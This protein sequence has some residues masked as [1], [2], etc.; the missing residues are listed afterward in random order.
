MSEYDLEM[1]SLSKEEAT[2]SQILEICEKYG[3]CVIDS[4]LDGDMLESVRLD[5]YRLYDDVHYDGV[6]L[7]RNL[8]YHKALNID[9]EELDKSEFPA[10]TDL[11]STSLFEGVTR[12]YFSEDDVQYPANLWAAKSLGT[13]DSPSGEPSDGTPFAYHFD[14]LNKF[15]FFFYL[16]DVGLDD[17]PTHFV[18]EYHKQYKEHR[19][20]WL[21]QNGDRSD[22]SNVTWHY[23]VSE[24]A[25]NKEVPVTGNAGTLL[26]F[27][28]D[29]P[30]R[31]GELALDHTRD[32]IRIDTLSPM[33]SGL[34]VTESTST[35]GL[36][37]AGLQNPK[38]AA[39]VL[40]KRAMG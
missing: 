4:F 28:T 35:S 36:V 5:Y 13:L 25:A 23:H 8:K 20:K 22:L 21:E 31:A 18:P 32:I 29:V 24:E 37:K 39:A 7:H 9:Y 11:V 40:F 16:S 17:G 14:R 26:I 2:Q 1:V 12:R 15:K 38:R 34:E 3:I 6:K 33:Q 10:I 27:D 30:H 19:R